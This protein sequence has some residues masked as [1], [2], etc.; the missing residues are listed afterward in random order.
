MGNIKE[1]DINIDKPIFIQGSNSNFKIIGEEIEKPFIDYTGADTAEKVEDFYEILENDKTTITVKTDFEYKSKH[2]INFHLPKDI[3]C[4]ITA[5]TNNGIITY[6]N[7]KGRLEANTRNGKIEMEQLTGTI[8]ATCAN[9]SINCKNLD[10]SINLS[11]ANGRILVRESAIQGD[12]S[13]KSGNGRIFLQVNPPPTGSLS[14]F[15]GNGKVR[16]A[17]PEHGNYSIQIKTKGRLFNN[18]EECSTRTE[19]ESTIIQKGEG[20]FNF[21]I[22]NYRGGVALLKYQDFDSKIDEGPEDFFKDSPFGEFFNG[23]FKCF[24][25]SGQ[26]HGAHGRKGFEDEVSDFINN[27]VKFG[28]R[29]GKMGEEISREFTESTRTNKSEGEIRIVLEML[30]EGRITAE[31]AEKLINA[32]KTSKGRR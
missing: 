29:F 32:I 23:M 20:G 22:Q 27:M 12:S 25:P 26:A 1:I 17:L 2:T 7:L 30:Q 19:N 10:S 4:N 5:E 3:K 8:A 28:S 9:G 6:T 21:L 24:E 18:L 16:L 14:I 15:S 13:I 31:E 11:S